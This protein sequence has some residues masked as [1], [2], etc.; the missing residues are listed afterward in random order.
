M[1]TSDGFD[2]LMNVR[3]RL[4]AV[5]SITRPDISI[6]MRIRNMLANRQKS[7]KTISNFPKSWVRESATVFRP[8]FE[9]KAK[10]VLKSRVRESHQRS[11]SIQA[12][13]DVNIQHRYVRSTIDQGVPLDTSTDIKISD[14]GVE[15]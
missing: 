8:V 3:R 12:R 10:P 4:P 13:I 2:L 9:T 1:V 15:R 5:V 14:I 6:R 7:I 11:S